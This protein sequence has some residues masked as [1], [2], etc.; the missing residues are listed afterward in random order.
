MIQTFGTTNVR[1]VR[2]PQGERLAEIQPKKGKPYHV[3]AELLPLAAGKDAWMRD[4]RLR[5]TGCGQPHKAAEL[6]SGLYCPAC[7]DEADRE[8]A[9]LDGR[10]GA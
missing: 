7:V 10:A 5:C 8:N 4:I 3:P 1:V 9:E 6:G 2:T